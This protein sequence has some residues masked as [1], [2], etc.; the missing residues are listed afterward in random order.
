MQSISTS[1]YSKEIFSANDTFR[2]E[3]KKTPRLHTTEP[4][5]PGRQTPPTNR[6]ER[7]I[8]SFPAQTRRGPESKTPS[9]PQIACVVLRKTGKASPHPS[10]LNSSTATWTTPK[11]ETRTHTQVGN[12]GIGLGEPGSGSRNWF[13]CDET[14]DSSRAISLPPA[15]VP[16]S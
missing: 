1:R 5:I 4:T 12:G 14:T 11:K 3:Q 7:E 15:S 10:A 9:L 6:R 8:C 2:Q 16:G 13:V